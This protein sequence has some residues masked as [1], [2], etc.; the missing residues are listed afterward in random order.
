MFLFNLIACDAGSFAE[1]LSESHRVDAV[2]WVEP[3]RVDTTRLADASRSPFFTAHCPLPTAYSFKQCRF[4]MPMPL[5]MLPTM[6]TKPW[7]VPQMKRFS[8]CVVPSSC[9]SGAP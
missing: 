6:P 7:S 2:K 5:T 3:Y 4:A 8:K 1:P 9:F